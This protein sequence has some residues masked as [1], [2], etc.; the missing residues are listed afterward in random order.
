[1]GFSLKLEFGLKTCIHLHE[2]PSSAVVE[3]PTSVPKVKGSKNSEYFIS[4]ALFSK[5]L[6]N[7]YKDSSRFVSEW[8]EFKTGPAKQQCQFWIR[9]VP[10]SERSVLTETDP[11]QSRVN[12]A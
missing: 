12:V 7:R 4:F 3:F 11:V 6:P 1:M 8:N 2:F 10:V 5:V 9:A